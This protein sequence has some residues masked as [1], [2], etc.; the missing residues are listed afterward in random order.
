MSLRMGKRFSKGE[1]FKHQAMDILT[2]DTGMQD[3]S[4]YCREQSVIPI[5]SIYA[6]THTHVWPSA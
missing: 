6:N 4:S 1:K 5:C 3:I 2:D